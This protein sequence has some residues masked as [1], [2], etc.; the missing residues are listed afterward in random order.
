M[1]YQYGYFI[2]CLIVLSIWLAVYIYRRDLRQEM[3]FSG[4]I[5]IPFG[6]T[7]FLF[8]P[9]YWNP[10]SLFNLIQRYGFGVESVL[11]AFAA[12]GLAAVFYEFVVRQK[13]VKILFDHRLHVLPYVFIILLYF[14]LE[15]FFPSKT[16][17]NGFFSSLAGAILIGYLRKD[18][19]KQIIFSGFYF[20]VFYFMLFFVFLR[21][22]PQYV[23]KFYNLKNFIG[24]DILGVPFEEIMFAFGLGACWSVFYEYIR[25]YRNRPLRF[26]K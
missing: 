23:T 11:F 5:T 19:I 21:F 9:E 7:E 10:P 8:V 3:L 17:Y 13:T 14:I 25:G 6:M 15:L 4:I 18:L 2:G 24:L 26:S 1:F 12:G 16:I 22:F 20:A